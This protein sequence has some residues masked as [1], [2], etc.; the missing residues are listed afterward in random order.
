MIL[1]NLFYLSNLQITVLHNIE[2]P[3]SET[4][5]IH[6]PQDIDRYHFK[7]CYT[8]KSKIQS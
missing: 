1:Y 7:A 5:F 6:R 2:Q 8:A 4:Q 3:N